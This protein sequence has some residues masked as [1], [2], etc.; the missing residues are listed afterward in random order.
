[1]NTNTAK[2]AT[3]PGAIYARVSSEEQT[4]G[5]SIQAQ[6][7]AGREWAEKQG[8]T[9][10]KEYL[11]EGFSA[12]RNL[13][14]REAFKEM[15]SDATSKEHPFDIILVHKLDRFSRDSLESLTARALFKR[16]EIRLLSVLEPMVGSD[17]PED[18]LVEHILMGMNQFYSQNLSREIRK[19][20][21]ERAQQHHLVFGPPFGYKK[22]I[23]ET[24]QSHKRTRTIS[25]AVIDEKTA[26]IVQRIFDLYDQGMGYKSIAMTLNNEGHRTNKG[27]LF[28]TTFIA[29]TLRN[30]AYI[31]ILD[32]NRC[33]DRGSREEINIPGFYPP[34]IDV[35]LFDNVQ[36]KLK[37]QIDLFHNS[38]AYRTEYLLS[39]LVVCD[40]CGHHYLG[41]SAKSG[42]YHYYSCRT[43]IQRG[44]E[45]CSAPLLNKEKLEK[46]VLDQIQ[47]QILSE[48]NVRK[49]IDLVIEQAR[50][51]KAEPGAEEKA[52][53]RTMADV[54]ARI[55]RWEDTLERGLL[56]LEESAHRIKDLRQERA[57]LLRRKIEL[58]KKSRSMAGVSP[59]PTKLMAE[60]I[61]EMQLRLREKKIGYKKDFLKEILQEVRVRNKEIT[62]TYKIPLPQRTPSPGGKNPRKEEF[63]TEEHLVEAGGIEPPSESLPSPRLH[64]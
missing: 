19:G 22:E 54:E 47:E 35:K 32:Y 59:I 12:S 24:Q 5:Y 63:F 28:R 4:Q 29:R 30:R 17:S 6:L 42:K 27:L 2:Q 39:R 11:D 48:E 15:L 8:Y 1:M 45:A 62:L 7:R 13:E 26:P 57:A 18:T 14:K 49:Y 40:L 50:V 38:Y 53:D 44:R 23:I 25:R 16:H 51:S 34:I 64:A 9:I 20:L 36:D 41:T 43:Y 61:R 60:Y 31:G 3:K 10:V 46:A 52:I 33:Q 55:R 56:S 58:E 21:K 37:T